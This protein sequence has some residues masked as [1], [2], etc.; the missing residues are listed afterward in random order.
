MRSD[1]TTF[2]PAKTIESVRLRLTPLQIGD[3]EEMADVLGDERLHEFIGGRPLTREELQDRYRALVAG[4]SEPSEGWLNWVV[5]LLPE[6]TA[7]GTVQA[8]VTGAGDGRLT[9]DVAWVMGIPWQGRAIGSEAAGALVDWLRGHGV[10]DIVASI[11]PDHHASESVA[12]HAGLH[13]TD[14]YRDGER[15]WRLPG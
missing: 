9:A 10:E 3:F 6:G 13:P 15:V 7:V 8:T 12:R 5:R 2:G 1:V 4:P 11:H 14:E